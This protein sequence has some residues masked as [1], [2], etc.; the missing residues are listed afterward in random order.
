M[1]IRGGPFKAYHT[2]LCFRLHIINCPI[3]YDLSSSVALRPEGESGTN[4]ARTGRLAFLS[5]LI[6]HGSY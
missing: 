2:T 3:R 5:V 1:V 4:L 6:G